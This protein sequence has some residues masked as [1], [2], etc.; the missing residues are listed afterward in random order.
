[1]TRRVAE[2]LQ[3]LFKEYTW[4]LRAFCRDREDMRL[5]KLLRMKRVEVTDEIFSPRRHKEVAIGTKLC[6]KADPLAD[7]GQEGF[8]LTMLTLLIDKSEA[9]RVYDRFEEEEI[10][11]LEG[12]VLN[13]S[14]TF[15]IAW[16]VMKDILVK[17]L[18]IL[19][20]A[21]GSPRET[22]Q[23]AF[24]N[25]IIDDDRWMQMLRVRNQLAHD[26]D[27][28]F[29]DKQFQNIITVYYLLFIKLR[30]HVEKYYLYR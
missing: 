15:D 28:T 11:V 20:F 14:L 1:M 23:Q 21:I 24:I 18:G 6:P 12:T 3:L 19:D 5:F 30:E 25:G 9:F 29:A 16:K 10:T 13:F 26:Y 27:G 2:P 7:G 4:Y 17:E 22:L 8:R